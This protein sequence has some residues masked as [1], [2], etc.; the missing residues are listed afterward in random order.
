MG[1]RMGKTKIDDRGRV[2]LPASM[3]EEAG[4]TPG[5]DVKIEKTDKGILIK[6]LITKEDFL[7]ELE[8]C[9]TEK[10]QAERLSPLELKKIWGPKLDID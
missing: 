1:I 6:P 4:L 2:T 8:G 10:N 7:K 9:I 3:R 5:K